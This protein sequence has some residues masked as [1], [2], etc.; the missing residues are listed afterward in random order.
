MLDML[1][2]LICISLN[3]H[4]WSGRKK[5][6][7]AD[8]NLNAGNIPPEELASLGVK[9]ICDPDDLKTFHSLRRRA[10]RVCDASGVR[11]LGG[12]TIPQGKAESVVDELRKVAADFAEEKQQ[13][14]TRYSESTEV[15]L[16]SLP[17]QWRHMVAEAI[18]P[19]DSIANRLSFSHQAFQVQGVEGLDDGLTTSMN[20]LGDRLIKEISRS[21]I[22]TWEA[23]FRG[24]VKVSQKALRPIRATLEKA[25]GLS[26]LD[27][28][29]IPVI[30][31]IEEELNSLPRS[32]YLGGRD[33]HQLVG[34]LHTLA[35]LEGVKNP[36]VLERDDGDENIEKEKNPSI[37]FEEMTP[38]P[39]AATMPAT[40][41]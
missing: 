14:L 20:S 16:N 2:K 29:L 19:I 28:N 8:L 24:R 11:F 13:F 7:P 4:I 37:E 33:F 31:G 21:A 10:E 5:L 17:P 6:R 34:V 26:F 22:Q 12:Y 27:G 9:K 39:L 38:E 15:W 23:S 3:V 41:F 35:D 32:G 25:K 1:N 40:W 30:T 36:V 18:E